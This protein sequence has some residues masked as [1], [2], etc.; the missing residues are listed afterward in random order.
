MLYSPDLTGN[1]HSENEV[2]VLLQAWAG[3]DESVLRQLTPLVYPEL[4]RLARYHLR[5]NRHGVTLQPTALV[6]EVWL[7]LAT[8]TKLDARSRAHF[9]SLAA[10]LM[11][12]ILV[13]HAR[14]STAAKRGGGAIRVTMGADLADDGGSFLDFLE[15]DSALEALSRFDPRKAR[16]I[17]LRYFAGLTGEEIAQLLDVGVAT[18]T[19][20]I[21]L[22][23]AWLHRELK[24]R[25]K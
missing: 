9:L 13:D 21:R 25:P 2:T 6:N 19:R 14:A 3:G 7:R 11:R 18:V 4:K 10:N 5:S 22:A 1:S 17:E 20:D 24:P 15:L 8:Q 12:Q 23:Q 16:M